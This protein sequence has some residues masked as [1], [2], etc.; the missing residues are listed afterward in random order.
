MIVNYWFKKEKL[1]FSAVFCSLIYK[2]A[3]FVEFIS[4]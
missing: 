3:V 4:S 2:I 1:T